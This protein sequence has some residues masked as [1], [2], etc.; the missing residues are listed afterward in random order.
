[1]RNRRRNSVELPYGGRLR[2]ARKYP[3]RRNHFDRAGHRGRS[4]DRASTARLATRPWPARE[5]EPVENKDEAEKQNPELGFRRRRRTADRHFYAAACQRRRHLD[6]CRG[7]NGNI[8][9]RELSFVHCGFLRRKRWAGRG[10]RPLVATKSRLFQFDLGGL[11]SCDW[12]RAAY[13]AR[14]ALRT[15]SYGRRKRPDVLS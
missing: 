1:M 6:D 14:S 15:E 4:A 9:F 8:A 13:P 3:R 11:R 10:A 2:H 7:G 5:S 12:R